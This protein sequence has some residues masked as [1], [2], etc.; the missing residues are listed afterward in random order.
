MKSHDRKS[1]L[2]GILS[3]A[4]LDLSSIHLCPFSTLL[5]V[6]EELCYNSFDEGLMIQVDLFGR[7]TQ[8]TVT[9]SSPE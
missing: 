7:E 9:F 6:S 5:R 2:L 3:N 1:F 8:K 4:K